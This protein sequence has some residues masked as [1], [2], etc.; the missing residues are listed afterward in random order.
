MKK[1]NAPEIAELNITETAN[2]FFDSEYEGFFVL[3][4]SKKPVKPEDDNNSDAVNS[5]S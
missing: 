3:N 2:G 4:D 1:W 5:L